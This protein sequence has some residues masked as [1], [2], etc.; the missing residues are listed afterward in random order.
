MVVEAD[1]VIDGGCGRP[2]TRGCGST[3]AVLLYINFILLVDYTPS[4]VGPA[5]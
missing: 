1:I 4:S 3:Y 2:V 5:P